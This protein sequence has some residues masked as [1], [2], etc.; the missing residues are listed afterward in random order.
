MKTGT[1]HF[2]GTDLLNH[3]PIL[4]VKPYSPF[5]DAL[6]SRYIYVFLY[7]ILYI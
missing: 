7:I 3:T 6:G 1:I 2:S 5:Y 4:D